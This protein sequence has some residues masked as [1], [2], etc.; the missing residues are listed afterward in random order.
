M[1]INL[2]FLNMTDLYHSKVILLYLT[3]PGDPTQSHPSFHYSTMVLHPSIFSTDPSTAGIGGILNDWHVSD[4]FPTLV[5]TLVV[6][7]TLLS[8]CF[9]HGWLVTTRGHCQ[10]TC[11]TSS[12]EPKRVKGQDPR[13]NDDVIWC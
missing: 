7:C 13:L 8:T 3:P 2:T 6:F 10:M 1:W 12:Q 11:Y 9:P 4:L 5:A